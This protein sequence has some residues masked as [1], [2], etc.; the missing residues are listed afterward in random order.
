MRAVV[1]HRH[2]GPEVLRLS[3]VPDPEPGPG[4]VRVA[5]E[6]IGL[7]YAEVLSRKGLY[8]WTPKMPYVLGMEAAGR[9]DRV[10]EGVE[11]IRVGDAVLVGRQAGAYAEY[12]V[13]RADAVLPV[14]EGFSMEEAAAFGVNYMTAWV[15]L[16]KMARLLPTDRVVVTAAAGGVGTAAVQIAHHHG[17]EVVALAGSDPKL[18]LARSLGAHH[19]VSYGV[20]DF[21]E[22]LWDTV[23][24]RGVDVVLETVGGRVFRACDAV[25][26]PFGRIVVAG[27]A[28]LDYRWWKPHTWWRAWRDAPRMSLESMFKR[29]VGLLS[30]HLGYLLGRTAH[31]QPVWRELVSFVERHGIRPVV[32]HMLPFEEVAEAHR[33]ME[34]RA[35][36]GKIVLRV[37]PSADQPEAR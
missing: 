32:G 25:L 24:E 34:S 31:L 7:N 3:R 23:G 6:A 26:A 15:A 11:G 16:M 19:T 36:K 20:P 29:S 10:G 30:T 14:P 13:Q 17:S 9:V 5:V 37:R 28:S 21:E 18:E 27:Y 12:V 2:G 22:R 8:G 33:L 1:L 35:S 4:E